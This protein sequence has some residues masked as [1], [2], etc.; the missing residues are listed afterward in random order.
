MIG[1]VQEFHYGNKKTSRKIEQRTQRGINHKGITHTKKRK[2]G[3]THKNF[4]ESK[5]VS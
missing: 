2:K 4:S 1:T 3:I 5:D